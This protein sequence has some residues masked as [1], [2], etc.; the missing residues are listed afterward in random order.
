MSENDFRPVEPPAFIVGVGASAGGLEALERFFKHMPADT[1]MAFVVVQH[2]SPDFKSLM[3]ELLSRITQMP[4]H[5]VE[6]GVTVTANAVYLLPPRKEMIISG[7]RLLLTEKDPHQGLS[8]PIDHFFRSLAHDCGRRAVAVVLSGTGSDGSR[9]V[10][11][12]HAAG[13]LVISQSE[14]TAKFDGMPSS[15]RD[16]GVVDLTLDP[17]DMPAALL[18]YLSRPEIAALTAEYEADPA[19]EEGLAAIFRLLRDQ[20]GIDFSFYKLNTVVRRTER[21]LQLNRIESVQDYLQRLEGDP[22]ELNAL[23]RD[24]LVGVTQFFRDHDAFDRL[25]EEIDQALKQLEPNAEFR[26]WVAGCATGEEAYSIAILLDERV[27]ALRLPVTVRVFATDVHR[28]SLE[29]ASHGLYRE[30]NIGDISQDRLTNYFTRTDEGYVV[31]QKLRQSVVFAP[32]NLIKDAP[33]TRMDL[34]TCRNLLIYLQPTAQKK[35]ITL[36][37]FGLKTGGMLFLGPS[38]STGELQDEF[39]A[40]DRHWN[41]Y[42][43]RRDIR[44]QA[45]LQ[46]LSMSGRSLRA[47]G[48]PE[49]HTGPARGVDTRLSGAYDALLTMFMPAGLL[50]D[51]QNRLLHV[52]GDA[53]RFLRI[54][55]GRPSPDVLDSMDS[56]LKLPVAGALRRA[57]LAK[58]EVC[59]RGV[60]VASPTEVERIDLAVRPVPNPRADVTDY[61][62]TFSPIE[63]ALPPKPEAPVDSEHPREYA[64][65]HIQALESELLYAK[66]NMQALVEELETGNEE[67]QATN[68]ELVASNEE[69]QSTNEELHSVNEEL[70]TVNAEHQRKIQQL[71]ELTHDMENLLHSTQVHTLFLDR[72]LR[73]RKYTRQ[74]GEIFNLLPVDIGR[75]IDGF[76]YRIKHERLH[77]EM[78]QVLLTGKVEQSEVQDDSGH[79]FLMRVLPYA[80]GG[81]ID[82]IV[83]TLV[84]IDQLKEVQQDLLESQQRFQRAVEGS[85]DGIWDWDFD[86]GTLY[87][88]P[89]FLELLGFHQDNLTPTAAVFEQCVHPEDQAELRQAVERHLDACTDGVL[90]AVFRLKLKDGTYRWF[91]ARGLVYRDSANQAIRYAGSIRD[92]T[93][94]HD[95]VAEKEQQVERRDM[96]LATLS[97]ELRNPLGAVL[98]AVRLLQQLKLGEG[99]PQQAIGI[100][101]R[102]SEQMASLLNDLLDVARISEGKID[103]RKTPLQLQQVIREASESVQSNFDKRD[104]PLRI[105]YPDEPVWVMGDAV[106]LRQIINNLLSNASKYSPPGE[107]VRVLLTTEPLQNTPVGENAA[108]G[109][110][111][112]DHSPANGGPAARTA[113][114]RVIDQGLGVSPAMQERIFH[115]FEQLQRNHEQSSGGLG[116]GLSLARTL[117]ELHGGGVSIYSRGDGY[118]SEFSLRLPILDAQLLSEFSTDSDSP[119]QDGE[120]CPPLSIVVVEDNSDA[121]EMLSALLESNGHRVRVAGDGNAGLDLIREARPDVAIVDVG[122]PGLDGYTVARRL[123][124]AGEHNGTL[125]VA[126]TGYGQ[127]TDRKAALDAGFDCHLTKPLSYPVLQKTLLQAVK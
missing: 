94:L 61:L 68:E 39:D 125:L 58:S 24:L 1:G 63:H 74:M 120:S 8:L 49:F 29:I 108:A 77:E 111:S 67:L 96:F 105:E 84:N 110:E 7:G 62:I 127:T 76:F 114:V 115:P 86:S 30:E 90:D 109:S 52:F 27:R 103:L 112:V 47:S 99:L 12:V 33:F 79:W 59:L 117:A 72:E 69:L 104:Q 55:A 107:S 11:D 16:T 36:F 73:I 91:Q 66:E 3:D 113:V 97:H 41:I 6:D 26:A 45:D 9:G 50:V 71:T 102:Q 23:Y 101:E 54:Q 121:R 80:T 78:Q 44:L 17:E 42:R 83:L 31:N 34:I 98:T 100:I 14:H 106:R 43:K 15:A 64:G 124:D 13:G 38:E 93:V 60:E 46:P 53:G 20:H 118:G 123:R 75:S 37:H 19:D 122:L 32:H 10:E 65:E 18:K 116:L 87:L 51:A 28:A 57:Q 35:V 81:D 5:R 40:I 48:L 56:R 85:L 82:G 126:L 88:S 70:Y 25:S 2:L 89:H 4:V 119:P 95:L 21:R 92:V 22:A